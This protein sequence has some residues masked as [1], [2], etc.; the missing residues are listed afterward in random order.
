MASAEDDIP[1]L[2][3]TGA[4]NPL[5]KLTFEVPK[6]MVPD[7]V[8]VKLTELAA[9]EGLPL[10]EFVRDL[11]T[12]RCFPVDELAKLHAA[13]LQRIAGNETK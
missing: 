13:R 6:L 7:P 1:L 4:T 8:G 2:S 12:V 5:G 11:L 3:R 10:S 9:A